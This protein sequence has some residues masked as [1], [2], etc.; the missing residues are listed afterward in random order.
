MIPNYYKNV[1]K[2]ITEIL[3][4]LALSYCS[5]FRNLYRRLR[6]KWHHVAGRDYLTSGSEV[7]NCVL[8]ERAFFYF[9]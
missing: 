8:P 3:I 9:K 6:F 2:N 1:I 7:G 4:G 5:D